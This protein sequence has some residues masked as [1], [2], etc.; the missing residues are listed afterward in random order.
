MLF[1]MKMRSGT[2]ARDRRLPQMKLRYLLCI[3]TAVAAFNAAAP[4]AHAGAQAITVLDTSCGYHFQPFEIRRLL[5]LGWACTLEVEAVA[6]R[7]SK[8]GFSSKQYVDG[9]QIFRDIPRLQPEDLETVIALHL[10]DINPKYYYMVDEKERLTPM[11]AF[12]R[13][14]TKR[15]RPLAIVGLTLAVAGAALATTGMVR[16]LSL[17]DYHMSPSGQKSE[18]SRMNEDPLGTAFAFSGFISFATGAVLGGVGLH[19]LRMRSDEDI[20]STMSMNELKDRRTKVHHFTPDDFYYDLY[21]NEPPTVRLRHYKVHLMIDEETV[22][23]G[24][25]VWF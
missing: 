2:P 19:K 18:Y 3:I 12:N 1:S 16:I 15:G 24:A 4:S 10:V 13:L 6:E 11:Q 21:N 23:L 7:L 17:E 25:V 9:Y 8:R 14:H 5:S 20:L 22:G